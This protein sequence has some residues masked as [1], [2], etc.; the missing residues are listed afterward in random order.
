MKASLLLLAVV[1]TGTLAIQL[2]AVAIYYWRNSWRYGRR[3]VA[4]VKLIQVWLD[5]WYVT[6]VWTDILT[7]Q[8]YTFQSP[9]I[10]DS[11]KQR[12]G[13]NVIVDI[14]PNDPERYWMRL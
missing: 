5:G 1:V 8:H 12:V 10:E 4:T 2:L 11:L 13:D 7:G 9:R 14:D 6:A 3:V